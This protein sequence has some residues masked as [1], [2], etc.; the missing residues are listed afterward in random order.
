MSKKAQQPRDKFGK[1]A[2]A[3][4]PPSSLAAPVPRKSSR[5]VQPSLSLVDEPSSPDFSGISD[6]PGSFPSS[7]AASPIRQNS[8][9]LAPLLRQPAL[10][11][12]T[13]PR[14]PASPQ[15]TPTRQLIVT[16]PITHTASTQTTAQ[17]VLTKENA[18]QTISQL[19]PSQS[20][21]SQTNPASTE[22]A[23]TQTT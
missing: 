5:P 1:F 6:L 15:L 21:A 13:F 9:P 16:Q 3:T 7:A 11:Q 22:S 8:P 17:R 10:S 4:P 19:A 20:T 18:I 2:K 23:S 12:T 14:L